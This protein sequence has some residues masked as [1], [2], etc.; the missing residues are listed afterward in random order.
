LNRA[1][2]WAIG[3]DPAT[4]NLTCVDAVY[5]ATARLKQ[6]LVAHYASGS[7][8]PEIDQHQ[9]EQKVALP[10]SNEKAFEKS[11]VSG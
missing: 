3:F 10:L 8:G 7:P 4:T 11:T 5:A 1:G 6:F 2:I 9:I